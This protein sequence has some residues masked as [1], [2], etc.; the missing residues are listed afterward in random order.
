[1]S[2][3]TRGMSPASEASLGCWD[4]HGQQG[5]IV[6]VSWSEDAERQYG[7]GVVKEDGRGAG[8]GAHPQTVPGGDGRAQAALVVASFPSRYLAHLDAG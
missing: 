8:H 4:R 2:E 3:V 1:V 6:H 7:T 5:A